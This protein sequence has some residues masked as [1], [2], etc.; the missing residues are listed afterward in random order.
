MS[1]VTVQWPGA[2]NA[3]VRMHAFAGVMVAWAGIERLAEG[4]QDKP[5][6]QEEAQGEWVQVRPRWPL[7]AENHPRCV[8]PQRKRKFRMPKRASRIPSESLTDITRAQR[9]ALKQGEST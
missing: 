1:R 7:T 6:T 3:R 9:L 8:P 5:P 2:M 4:L